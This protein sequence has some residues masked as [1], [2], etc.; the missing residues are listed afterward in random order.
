MLDFSYSPVSPELRSFKRFQSSLARQRK[1]RDAALT[2]K[3]V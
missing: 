3:V 1:S 2:E